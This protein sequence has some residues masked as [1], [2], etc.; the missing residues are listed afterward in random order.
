MP[1]TFQQTCVGGQKGQWNGEG[2]KPHI[3][4]DD[5]FIFCGW[6]WCPHTLSFCFFNIVFIFFWQLVLWDTSADPT[7]AGH[8]GPPAQYS[9]GEERPCTQRL[10]SP[11][12]PTKP[13][14]MVTFGLDVSTHK[15]GHTKCSLVMHQ[16]WRT[17]SLCQFI[18]CVHSQRVNLNLS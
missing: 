18:C 16:R 6:M 3:N 10:C 11:K 8:K 5:T 9:C 4:C 15:E 1:C 14:Q 17:K 2:R 13:S 7:K 12:S